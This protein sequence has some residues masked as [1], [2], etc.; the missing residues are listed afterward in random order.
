M[1]NGSNGIGHEVI[2]MED[3]ELVEVTEKI[4]DVMLEHYLNP[5]EMCQ[6]L[7]HAQ[8]AVISTI[9]ECFA[10]EMKDKMIDASIEQLESLRGE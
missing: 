10:I 4:T 3:C 2:K 1:C 6:T 9:G 5:G 7:S 8:S